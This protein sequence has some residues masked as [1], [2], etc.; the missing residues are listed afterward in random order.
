[1]AV[2]ER[3]VKGIIALLIIIAIIPFLTFYQK[4]IKPPV[5]PPFM[6]Q[7]TDSRVIEIVSSRFLE[8]GIYF[9][10]SGM[11]SDKLLEHFRRDMSEKDHFHLETL[12]VLIF[13]DHSPRP[14]KAPS[15][16]EAS[17]RLA[18]GFP[19]DINSATAEELMMIS[20]I[21]PVL[22]SRITEQRERYGPYT[23]L[24]QLTGIRGIKAKTM[25]KITGK[26]CVDSI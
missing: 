13:E 22:A 8:E 24:N 10:P 7:T 5:V 3:Q 4:S 6:N 19:M 23:H 25:Q 21:G 14:K 1:M 20:G 17:K 12:T 15:K 26:L 18:L 11:P 9:M 2:F 16:I